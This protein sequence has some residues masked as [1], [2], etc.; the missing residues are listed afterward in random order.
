MRYRQ[1][2]LGFTL[3]ECLISLALGAM[4]IVLAL[5][6][7]VADMKNSEVSMKALQRQAAVVTV[8]QWMVND[9]ANAGAFGG[10]R[11][12]ARAKGWVGLR[13]D[14]HQLSLFY[15]GQPAVALL[16]V[17]DDGLQLDAE[18]AHRFYQHAVLLVSTP[19][20]IQSVVVAGAH[21]GLQHQRLSLQTSLSLKN[22]QA[23]MIG[24]LVA[25]EFKFNENQKSI[26]LKNQDG[27]F[28]TLL[29][30]VQGLSFTYDINSP[31]GMSQTQTVSAEAGAFVCGVTIV[32]RVSGETFVR[33]APVLSQCV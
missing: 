9:I 21:Y 5:S 16:H 14:A 2:Y 24:A 1:S 12:A 15:Q 10:S 17:S 4:I 26:T 6:L 19:D 23:A 27:E 32:M 13:G 29:D 31:Q 18:A 25:H 8:L 7:F 22:H 33:Y 3:L 28:E 30:E 20:E 11:A